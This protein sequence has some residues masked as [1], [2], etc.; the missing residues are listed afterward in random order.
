VMDWLR[1][2]RDTGDA[3]RCLDAAAALA[4]HCYEWR[5]ILAAVPDLPTIVPTRAAELCGRTLESAVQHGQVNAFCEVAEVRLDVLDDEDGARQALRA[6]E[7]TL[8]QRD[9]HAYEWVLLADGF[10]DVVDDAAG[11]RRCLD[12]GRAAAL[13]RRD[14][15]D[16]AGVAPPL[17]RLGDRSAAL[18][19]VAEAEELL[20]THPPDD[21]FSQASA[22]WGIVNA[23]NE[24]GEHTAASRLLDD[25]TR[26][27]PTTGAA[28][29]L[30][31]AWHTH[32]DEAGADR[33]LARAAELAATAE[34]WLDLGEVSRS[35]SRDSSS[36]RTAVDR[37][38]AVVA[39]D[40]WRERVATAYHRWL[41]DTAAADRLG[42]RGVAPSELR[43]VLRSLPGW[44]ATPAPLFDFLR[45][46]VSTEVLAHISTADYGE[47]EEDNLA[48]LVDIWTTGLIPR[49]L[50]W[51]PHEVLALRRWAGGDDVDHVERAW[52]CTLLALDGEDLDSVAAGLVDSCLALGVPSLAEQFLAWIWSTSDWPPVSGLFALLLLRA[53]QNPA[54]PRIDTLLAMI[55]EQPHDD[56]FYTESVVAELWADLANRVLPP[57]LMPLRAADAD[58][59]REPPP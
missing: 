58:P 53:A 33:A 14:P 40:V 51:I 26:R 5:M 7:E 39:D 28:L 59:D 55:R 2:A 25:A 36:I 56:F 34:E 22:V 19:V 23:W 20:A 38:A 16:L 1:E 13:R 49:Q 44:S 46:R 31:R 10:I 29:S 35:L 21:P 47:N 52:C 41:G 54:D 18:A 11:A 4:R 12:A 50:P 15:N 37:A 24:L 43:V 32:D 17:E 48:A 57:G 45:A 8:R 3:E 42:P 30:A 9:T 6:G 27:A